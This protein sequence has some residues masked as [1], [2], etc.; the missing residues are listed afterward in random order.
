M[1]ETKYLP[2]LDESGNLVERSKSLL[3][4]ASFYPD[5][6]S[7]LDAYEAEG[8]DKTVYNFSWTD[9]G[10]T[11][12]PE[13]PS[14]SPLRAVYKDMTTVRRVTDRRLVVGTVGELWAYSQVRNERPVSLGNAQARVA[15]LDREF[16]QE[17]EPKGQGSGKKSKMEGYKDEQITTVRRAF[18]HYRNVA[19]FIF[20]AGIWRDGFKRNKLTRP[21][22]EWIGMV[23]TIE[24]CLDELLDSK[25][26]KWDPIRVP[27]A[28]DSVPLPSIDQENYLERLARAEFKGH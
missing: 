12:E 28:F 19:H 24:R 20:V 10:V 15:L 7:I 26:H 18:S 11:V 25:K 16:M 8:R 21:V 17:R 6:P 27:E 23:L 14:T 4:M 2:L 13:V 3:W 5:L 9:E 22:T 1:G